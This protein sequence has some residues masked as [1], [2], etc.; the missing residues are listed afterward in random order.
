M[1][2]KNFAA[3]GIILLA[4]SGIII[5]YTGSLRQNQ[6][7]Q[8]PS[9]SISEM[10]FDERDERYAMLKAEFK[11]Y[12]ML[13]S[14]DIISLVQDHEFLAGG[15]RCYSTG[16]DSDGIALPPGFYN[17]TSGSGAKTTFTVDNTEQYF[18]LEI[19]YETKTLKV[20]PATRDET[21]TE[22]PY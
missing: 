10:T 17:V 1:N 15:L 4:L 9:K 13:E 22:M 21:Y 3:G 7:E 20:R 14:D 19:D 16:P 12:D 8:Q 6:A 11:N 2:I 5:N 18:I